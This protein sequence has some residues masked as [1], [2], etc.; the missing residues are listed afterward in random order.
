M[1][2]RGQIV[3]SLQSS[4]EG[5]ITESSENRK[6]LYCQFRSNKQQIASVNCKAMSMMITFIN[7]LGNDLLNR[8]ANEDYG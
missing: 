8:L 2:K 4:K 6:L 5:L 7:H 3:G 1:A